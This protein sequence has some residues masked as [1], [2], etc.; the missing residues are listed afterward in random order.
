MRATPTTG[1]LLLVGAAVVL[2][3]VTGGLWTQGGL[4]EAWVSDTARDRPVNH[5]AAAAGLVGESGM[6][7]APISGTPHT[8]QC[9]L[10]G[11]DGANGS[12]RWTYPIPRDDCT[13]HSVADP[14][15]ADYDGDGVEEV[16]VA[17]TEESIVGIDGHSGV[18][19]FRHELTSYGYTKPIVTDLDGEAGMEIVAVDAAGSVVV[20]RPDGSVVWERPRSSH[21][22]GQPAVADFDGDGEPELV[23]GLGE[24]GRLTMFEADGRVAWNRTD[25]V[26]GGAITWM[27]PGQADADPAAEVAI[28][29][30]DGVVAMVDGRDGD[31][32][33]RR[34]LGTLAAV[35]AFG[36]GDGDGEVELYAVAADAVLRSYSA[37]DGTIE[38][39]TTLT[40]EA[41]QMTPPP[42]LGDVDG[43]GEQE[44][45]AVTNDGAVSIVDP[46]TG[47]VGDTY[48]R[49][50][51]IW[52]YPTLADVDGDGVPEAF[53]IYGDGRVV[54][55]SAER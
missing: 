43:D 34:D 55:L 47:E 35:H 28:A 51:P 16:F 14:T 13:I 42:A 20:L 8:D 12:T 40:T 1:T 26:D 9:A 27:V 29:T 44:L 25:V 4:T 19:E 32:Q 15:I 37:S 24:A 23:V 21:T 17:T 10:V 36:D 45:V 2:V 49:D 41:V 6:V 38:W 7:F 39:T 53:V 3:A 31:V 48:R 46:E 50:V 52:T 22:W 33:W 18:V 11:L 54:S 30:S 5:H